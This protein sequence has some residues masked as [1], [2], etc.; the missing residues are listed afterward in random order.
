MD[1]REHIEDILSGLPEKPGVY[2]MKDGDGEI[3]Y[4]GKARVLKNRVRQY[5]RSSKN[6]APKVIA[7][8]EKV[9]D[10]DYIITA[11]EMEAL[12]LECNLIKENRPFYNILMKDV[13]KRQ[14]L[15]YAGTAIIML[16]AGTSNKWLVGGA[17]GAVSV[18]S[19]L[20]YKLF[21]H[22]RVRVALWQNPWALYE[23][24]GYQ[25]VQGLI[26]IASGGLFG[27]GL[28]MGMPM[29][30]LLYTS[31]FHDGGAGWRA[32]H[33]ALPVI[34]PCGPLA[35]PFGRSYGLR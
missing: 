14:A 18:G 6:H 9:R 30:C 8:V 16:Y 20:A 4:I 5:F 32:G 1:Y 22:V 31:R 3:I 2:I 17:V 26:A 19:V 25:V 33:P 12:V 11:T 23:S 27:L 13:Y 35:V 24:Q 7:M 15:L 34:L 10:I 21:P 28:T 29:A